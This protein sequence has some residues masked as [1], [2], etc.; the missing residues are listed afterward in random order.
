MEKDWKAIQKQVSSLS[1]VDLEKLVLKGMRNNKTYFE[2][3]WVNYL[4]K[5]FGEEDLL[6]K[7]KGELEN[8]LLKSYRG[9]C[10]E[11][12][13]AAAID[14]CKKRIEELYKVAR[15]KD[16]ILELTLYVLENSL[17]EY[18]KLAGTCFTRYDYAYYLLFKKG[19]SIFYSLHEE[20]QH[21]FRGRLQKILL[22]LKKHSSHM[23][24]VYDLPDEV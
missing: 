11:L 15:Q 7:G 4:D 12:R 2:F 16:K 13:R 19:K 21:E 24:Y 22:Q 14:S 10:D 3:V 18:P 9:R 1:K 6:E 23:D 17:A 8:L 20:I 5:E